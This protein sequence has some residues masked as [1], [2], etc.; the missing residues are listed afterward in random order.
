M[1][2]R[3]FNGVIV[4]S[5]IRKNWQLIYEEP[6]Q[7]ISAR[8]RARQFYSLILKSILTAGSRVPPFSIK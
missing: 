1:P 8:F 2:G 7:I 3:R 4:S 5:L 6:L